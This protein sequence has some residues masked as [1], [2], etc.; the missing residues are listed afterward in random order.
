MRDRPHLPPSRLHPIAPRSML[1]RKLELSPQTHDICRNFR[2]A[3][4]WHI[5]STTDPLLDS[6]NEL[7]LE[8]EHIRHDYSQSRCLPFNSPT[9]C[10]FILSSTASSHQRP[11]A[12]RTHSG[13]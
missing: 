10:L 3:D 5:M 8:A 11:P 2:V 4:A 7:E 1:Q 9:S 13:V 12:Q 6:D